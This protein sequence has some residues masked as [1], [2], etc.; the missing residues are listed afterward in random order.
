MNERKPQGRRLVALLL[1]AVMLVSL[2]PVAVFAA[3][4]GSFALMAVTEEGLLIEPA[5]VSYAQGATVGE[6]LLGSGYT[7]TGIDTG[8]VT[9]VN[10]TSGSFTL[11]GA[12]LEDPAAGVTA[13][14]LTTNS[15]QVYGSNL[16]GLLQKM[17]QY[18]A[19]GS[20]VQSDA[21]AQAA[22]AAAASGFYGADDAAA[23]TPASRMPSA[24]PAALPPARRRFWR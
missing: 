19:D 22:Y 24:I 14:W 4:G 15:S 13:L 1:T 5:Y 6:A 8:T 23:G 17:A 18:K 12:A 21:D 9:A 10:G 16:A 11:C 7:F 2:L 20:G 3:D